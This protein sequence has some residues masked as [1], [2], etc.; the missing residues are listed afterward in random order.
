[1]SEQGPFEA[2]RDLTRRLRAECPWDREQTVRTIVPHTIEEAYEVADA[3]LGGQPEKLADELGDLLFQVVFLALLLEEQGD[4]DLDGIIRGLHDKLVRRHPHVFGD[5]IADTAGRVRERWEQIK[6]EQEGRD[7]IFHDVPASLPALLHAR[8]VQRRAAAV[9]YDWPDLSGPLAKI[10][11]EHRELREA[12][13]RAG[14]V[15]PECEADP[16]VFAEVG[17]LL[18][19]VVNVARALNVDPELALRAT[20]AKFVDRVERAEALAAT[21]G[22]EWRTLPLDGQERYYE[23]VK[24]VG[25]GRREP[26]P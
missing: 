2:L 15:A 21:E 6:R 9:G 26:A 20:S 19:T 11:E 5:S 7:G 25:S 13:A 10:D 3:A 16:G 18:F 8:K 4:G 23:R 1:M 14:T 12:I 22:A 24:A 17:D